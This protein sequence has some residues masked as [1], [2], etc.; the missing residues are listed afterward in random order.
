MRK[1]LSIAALLAA[2]TVTFWQPAMAADVG[3]VIH[4]HHW[5]H[6]RHYHRGYW[7]CGNYYR[8]YYYYR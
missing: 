2:S 5:R 1:L 6:H 4:T 3:V 8:G 7:Y